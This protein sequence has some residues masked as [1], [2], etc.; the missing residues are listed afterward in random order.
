MPD[1]FLG[2]IIGHP[3]LLICSVAAAGF[4]V[5]WSVAAYLKKRK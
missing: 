1:S 3:L 5:H 4:L 2:A